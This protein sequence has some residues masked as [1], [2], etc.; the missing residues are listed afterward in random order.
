[1]IAAFLPRNAIAS[2]ADGKTLP[3]STHR[4]GFIWL[5]AAFFILSGG[6]RRPAKDSLIFRFALSDTCLPFIGDGFPRC[7]SLSF[8]F[9]SSVGLIPRWLWLILLLAASV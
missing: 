5:S 8:F 7:D 9:V 6:R 4:T 3:S 1:M 2:F